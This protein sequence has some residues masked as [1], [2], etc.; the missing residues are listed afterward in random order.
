MSARRSSSGVAR[1]TLP[2]LL[3]SIVIAA[4]SAW[5]AQKTPPPQ[6]ASIATA[7]FSAV[8]AMQHL[9]W[10]ATEPHP[11]G[12]AAAARVRDQLVNHL[13][14][15]GLQV[16]VQRG[17][18]AAEY[19]KG[20]GRGV[21]AANVGNVVAV[22]PG[23]D[24]S[25]PAVL[26]MA[27]YDTVPH[28]PGAAD[29][30][31]GVA[32]ML[33]ISRALQ[34]DLRQRDV[35]FLFTDAEEAGLLG[36]RAFFA[37]HPLS[38]RIGTVIN[39]EARGSSGR[40]VLFETGP[41]NAALLSTFAKLA[42]QPLGNSLT[43][44]VYRYMPNGTDFTVPAQK[45]IPGLNFAIIG[46]Q[47]DYHAAT[48]SV[49]NLDPGS[50]QHMGA[51]VLPLV[52]QLASSATLPTATHDAIYSDLPGGWMISV[53]TWSGW[54]VLAFGLLVIVV[55]ARRATFNHGGWR[56]VVSGVAGWPLALL[57]V[58]LAVRVSYRLLGGGDAT[59]VNNRDLL[60]AFSMLAS[61][62]GLLAIGVVLA[63][64][65]L[66]ACKAA[67]K[68]AAALALVAGACASLRGGF[69]V[70]G[71][72]LGVLVALLAWTSA[73]TAA[74]GESVRL[75]ALLVA[76]IIGAVVQVLAPELAPL[77]LWPLLAVAAVVWLLPAHAP[78]TAVRVIAAAVITAFALAH[79]FH[80][81]LQLFE[82][83]GFG[84][85]EVLA[86]PFA[87]LAAL[88]LPWVRVAEGGRWLAIAAL[89][90]VLPAAGVLA[91]ASFTQADRT[92]YPEL[93]QVLFVADPD[94]QHYYRV[95]SLPQ[96]SDWSRQALGGVQAEPTRIP[97]PAMDLTAVWA[98]KADAIAVPEP[99]RFERSYDADTGQSIL[100][101][102]A[103]AGTRE[104]RVR[105]KSEAV[106]R[107]VQLQGEDAPLL[108]EADR[109]SRLRWQ[110]PG[111]D[112]I[113]LRW[114][115]DSGPVEVQAAAGIDGWPKDAAPLPARSAHIV[116][117]S[118]SDMTWILGATRV[119]QEG[120][121]PQDGR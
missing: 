7:E 65:A 114:P 105:L 109:W 71:L 10:I 9:S 11:T 45:G 5:S 66:L 14:Q 43:G 33:E 73:G 54:C 1:Y 22:L 69:D 76:W 119:S 4:W 57:S 78:P 55:V 35:V 91:A 94:N 68:P 8:R 117:W 98:T 40:A 121:A 6:P 103:P 90:T 113:E 101:V 27:H 70:I 28:S 72:V 60:A 58:A 24:R 102:L 26:L 3:L 67:R 89:V 48:A 115:S 97:I 13:Q 53:P 31:L 106:V 116:P 21:R 84:T 36:A 38:S 96:L 51:Q 81:A 37:S 49:A 62:E 46:S 112:G 120:G 74:R 23:R 107:N 61:G 92:R 83:I 15:A 104:L 80:F 17:Q 16:S 99:V 93:S 42:Q 64:G 108:D 56:G 100:R 88:L 19:G 118:T 25:L 32:V 111:P 30:G 50:V 95:S 34:N 63:L 82:A 59:L 77:L 44:F 75:G 86:L 20:D 85:P 41:G 110:A 2:L 18:A 87:S 52:R 12:S 29:D 39:L 79:V 47:I